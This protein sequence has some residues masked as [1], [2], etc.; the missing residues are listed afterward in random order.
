MEEILMLRHCLKLEGKEHLYIMID[1]SLLLKLH[2]F[3]SAANID[4]YCVTSGT[5]S[6]V[7]CHSLA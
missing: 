2:T 3:L 4:K 7:A 6:W 1:S 5:F